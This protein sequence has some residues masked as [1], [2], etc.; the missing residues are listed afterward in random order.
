M[1]AAAAGEEG[2]P[3]GV[4][5]LKAAVRYIRYNEGSIPGSMERIFTFGMS[6]GGA[7]SALM[8]ATG[9]SE[10]YLP[11]LEAIGAR[12]GYQRRRSRLHVLVPGD[13]S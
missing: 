7:Q 3:A 9:D 5:D 4:T 12:D 10:L 1:Q 2:A 11:Y 6:G 8:G 13:K